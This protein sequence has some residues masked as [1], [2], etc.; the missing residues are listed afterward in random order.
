MQK[1]ISK[2]SDN[3]RRIFYIAVIFAFFAMFDR[4]L[5]GPFLGHLENVQVKIANE[6]IAIQHD[7]RFLGYKDRIE[8]ESLVF[9]K[10]FSNEV[11]DRDVISAEFLRSMERL[12]R[13]TNI[14]FS[15]STLGDPVEY[16][17]HLEYSMTLDCAGVLSDIITF[18]H[19]INTS[20]S[21]MKVVQFSISP[22]RGTENNVNISLKVIKLVT[23][24]EMINDI[25]SS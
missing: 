10:F 18:M 20:D 11:K 25:S 7:L 14:D 12:A 23:N 15:K 8:A 19:K 21:L 16:E 2:L 9:S 1:F 6:K 13:D 3:E 22:K 17:Y 5:L 24:S 4:L